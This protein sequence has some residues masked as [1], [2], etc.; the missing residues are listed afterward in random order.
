[1][2]RL[3]RGGR[4]RGRGGFSRSFAH[5]DDMWLQ[6]F[7]YTIID[8]ENSVS[9]KPAVLPLLLPIVES[10]SDGGLFPSYGW[11]AKGCSS[12]WGILLW[13]SFLSG[14]R[15]DSIV[16]IVG[17]HR[18]KH[19]QWRYG[20]SFVVRAVR[21]ESYGILKGQGKTV[22]TSPRTKSDRQVSNQEC[23]RCFVPSGFPLVRTGNGCSWTSRE[24]D[25]MSRPARRVGV[26]QMLAE[27]GG[28]SFSKAL[29]PV[30]GIQI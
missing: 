14:V 19:E 23:H 10:L 25:L 18:V 27:P 26:R 28:L 2:E 13:Q 4:I 29:V 21:V 8:N 12:D 5:M 22:K 3:A 15:I 30:S 9:S 20:D 11:P 7:S 6:S 1:M 17:N 16:T 24:Q